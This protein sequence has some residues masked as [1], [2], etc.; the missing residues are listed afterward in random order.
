MKNYG[1]TYKIIL[2]KE[3]VVE[4]DFSKNSFNESGPNKNMEYYKLFCFKMWMKL[5]LAATRQGCVE[6]ET[7]AFRR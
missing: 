5:L 1:S 2:L 6:L 3:Y 4:N 7:K